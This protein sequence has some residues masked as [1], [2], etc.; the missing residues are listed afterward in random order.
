MITN[1]ALSNRILELETSQSQAYDNMKTEFNGVLDSLNPVNLLKSKLTDLLGNYTS[2]AQE[3]GI[4]K[5][6][7]NG[8]K[9][10]LVTILQLGLKKLLTENADIVKTLS[11]VMYHFFTKE[12]KIPQSNGSVA[13]A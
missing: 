13:K 8:F 2:S 1:K 4:S 5:G 10:V 3:F 9:V 6:M 11:S 7:G 12:K